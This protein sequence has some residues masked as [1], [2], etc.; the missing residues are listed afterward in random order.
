MGLNRKIFIG[1]IVE[2]PLAVQEICLIGL[3]QL[4]TSWKQYVLRAA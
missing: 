1:P 2:T 4:A 3:K